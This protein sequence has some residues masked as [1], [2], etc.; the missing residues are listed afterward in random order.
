MYAI[1]FDFDDSGTPYFARRYTRWGWGLAR[2]LARAETWDSEDAAQRVLESG[3]S[4]PVRECGAVVE[5][6]RD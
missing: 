6:G 1:C 2:S 4:Q 3:Y 5:V